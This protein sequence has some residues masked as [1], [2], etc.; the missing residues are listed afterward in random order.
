MCRHV[1]CRYKDQLPYDQ[2][3]PVRLTNYPDDLH[4][5]HWVDSDNYHMTYIDPFRFTTTIWKLYDLHSPIS[6]DNYHMTYIAPFG[7]IIMTYI[8][9]LGWQLHMTY[10]DLFGLTIT[11][12]P[13][14]PHLGWQ[15]HITYIDLSGLTTTIWRLKI[16]R[17]P[18]G[19]TI[20]DTYHVITGVSITSDHKEPS[21]LITILWL[22]GMTNNW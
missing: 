8:S 20:S 2:Y 10:I 1:V 14:L 13:I 21:G 6:I 7:L 19:P 5:L 9:H 3:Y 11:I 4:D 22:F 12:W 16:A 17:R 18:T 15:L